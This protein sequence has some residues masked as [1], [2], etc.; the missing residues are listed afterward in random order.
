MLIA[1]G[2]FVIYFMA[3]NRS[4]STRTTTTPTVRPTLSPT[5]PLPRTPSL[6]A[7]PPSPSTTLPL[8]FDPPLPED[9]TRVR[10]GEAV[11]RQDL[12]TERQFDVI[13]DVNLGV[14]SGQSE[15]MIM[16][17][18]QSEIQKFLMP[19]LVGCS[20]ARNRKLRHKRML[21][22]PNQYIVGNA[23]VQWKPA[24]E[25]SDCSFPICLSAIF[26]MDLFLK[27]AEDQYFVIMDLV[28]DV[29]GG[30]LIDS[31]QLDSPPFISAVVRS[32]INRNPTMAPSVSPLVSSP[33]RGV[34]AVTPS[35]APFDRESD[36]IRDEEEE[37]C[38]KITPGQGG[39]PPGKG[40]IPPG[41]QCKGRV[42]PGLA[43]KQ[44]EETTP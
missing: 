18:L 9:C 3:T 19:K 28:A 1:V 15:T 7:S 5:L 40:G 16:D 6:S 8:L 22:N 14:Q 36:T 39:I 26:N 42:P 17:L 4:E 37:P 24:S 33:T 11:L 43:K 41:Q 2:N 44:A 31:L 30:D 10:N 27:T 20:E 35:A 29:F 38:R 23:K 21:R 32:V 34:A 25:N 13:V 12:L